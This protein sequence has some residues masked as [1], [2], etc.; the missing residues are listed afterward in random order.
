MRRVPLAASAVAAVLI[1]AASPGGGDSPLPLRAPAPPTAQPLALAGDGTGSVL[2]QL[3]PATLSPLRRSA[4][5]AGGA[6]GWTV[7]PE[8]RLLAIDT[9]P[10]SSDGSTSTLR[11]ANA[12]T[13]RWVRRG[14]RLDGYFVAASWPAESRLYA[15][16]GASSGSGL[17]L[18]TVDTVAKKIVAHKAIPGTAASVA[19]TEGGLVVL[20]EPA[21]AV[22]P[23]SLVVVGREG[24]VR[25]VVL[26]RILA[27][28]HVDES[29]NDP[30]ATTRQPGLAVDAAN[31]VA[32]VV[33]PSGLVAEI[34]L[35]DLAVAYHRLDRSFL[36]RL[37][38]WLT[39]PAEAK[40]L[41]GPVLEATWLGDGLIAVTGTSN[42]TTRRKDGST[43]FSTGPAGLRVV[44]TH[45][46][47]ERTLDPRTDTAV[48]ADGLLLASGGRWSNGDSQSVTGAEGLAAYGSDGTL[49]WRLDPGTKFWIE[50]VVGARALVQAYATGGTLQP[51]Q[52]VDLDSG[53][54]VRTLSPDSSP[55][56]LVGSG[57]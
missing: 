53:T 37:A 26:D 17:S 42:S 5:L 28:T 12:A 55:W 39:P 54:V 21:N 34:R 15:L 13:L 36:S 23:A 57:S 4:R 49:R 32:Y 41:E 3:D 2:E 16:T 18:Q 6:S 22:A 43:V 29:S 14:I 40:G 52:L 47:S 25:S 7:S 9:Y 56:P 24:A 31:G 20:G 50:A 1:G 27:G 48:V 44:D 46:W 33:D 10:S 30:I 51:I 35:A 8:H 11:F 19:H 45:D 38:G